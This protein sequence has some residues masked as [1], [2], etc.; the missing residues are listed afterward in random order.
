MTPK[1]LL[2][3]DF[4]KFDPLTASEMALCINLGPK[5]ENTHNGEK[6]RKTEHISNGQT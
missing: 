1:Y 4:P 6:R 2:L 5:L 3:I